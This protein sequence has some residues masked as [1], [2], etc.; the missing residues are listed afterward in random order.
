M[1]INKRPA[2]NICFIHRALYSEDER[3]EDKHKL[4]WKLYGM[5][6]I[7]QHCNSHMWSLNFG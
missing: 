5:I 2:V 7:I 3:G 1:T 6:S 4:D